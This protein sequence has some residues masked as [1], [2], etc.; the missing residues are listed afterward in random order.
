M[1]IIRR[2]HQRAHGELLLVVGKVPAG[3][4]QHG[5]RVDEGGI[6]VTE[7]GGCAVQ[8]G[9]PPKGP[10]CFG[11]VEVEWP[12]DDSPGPLPGE[13]TVGLYK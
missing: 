4:T 11:S 1:P 7:H 2:A 5:G 8:S 12:E 3:F 9:Q 10:D 13:E 6:A